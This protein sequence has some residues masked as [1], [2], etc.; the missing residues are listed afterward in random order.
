MKK[1]CPKTKVQIIGEENV[2]ITI[3][4]SNWNLTTFDLFV[5]LIILPLKFDEFTKSILCIMD[6]VVDCKVQGVYYKTRLIFMCKTIL[7]LGGY[8]TVYIYVSIWVRHIFCLS[9]DKF[10]GSPDKN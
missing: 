7:A 5:S 9:L 10:S 4:W 3:L 8:E 2:T 6:R 1:K